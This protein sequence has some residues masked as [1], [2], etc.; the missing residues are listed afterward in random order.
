M[1]QLLEY[2]LN[3]IIGED[4]QIEESEENGK[5]SFNVKVPQEL[6]GTLIGKGGRVIKAIQDI[7]RIKAKLENKIVFINVSEKS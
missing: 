4:Y 2:I 5:V 1:R 6:I 3:Q 7:L